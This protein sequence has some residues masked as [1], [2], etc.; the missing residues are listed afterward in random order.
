[1]LRFTHSI[2]AGVRITFNEKPDERIRSLL[3]ANGFRWSPTG[4]HWWRTRVGGAADFLAALDRAVGPRKPDGPCWKCKNPDGYF[5]P[6]GAATPVY[7][8]ACYAA[9]QYPDRFDMDYEDRCR[10]ACGH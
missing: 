10:E 5:R 2:G 7:C 8:E 3:K 9:E 1:M 4:G 6:R